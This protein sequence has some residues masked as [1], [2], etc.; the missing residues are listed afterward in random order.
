MDGDQPVGDLGEDAGRHRPPADVR[1]GTSLGRQRPPED[2][3]LLVALATGVADPFGRRTVRRD[4]H[5]PVDEGPRRPGPDQA[6]VRAPA[7]EQPEPLDNHGL[8]G[9]GLAADHGQ[10]GRQL[11][12]GV[13]D[14]PETADA[15]LLEHRSDSMGC[16]VRAVGRPGN[17]HPTAAAPPGSAGHPHP[18]TCSGPAGH[19][20][21][22]ACPGPPAQ[23]RSPAGPPPPTRHRKV[24]LRH[25]PVGEGP[26]AHH[27]EPHRTA[28]PHDLDPGERLD[29]H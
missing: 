21:P 28:S 4:D 1:A 6:G 16:G 29:V 19:P 10:A 25:Q 12:H 3:A 27:G 8:A 15:N 7:G 26:R 20:H 22:A 13:V 14:D 2:E 11:E 24:E 17:A 18:P 23:P 5:P 9:S